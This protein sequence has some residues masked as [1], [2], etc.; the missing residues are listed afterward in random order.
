MVHFHGYDPVVEREFNKA[1]IDSALVIVNYNGFSSVYSGPF[2]NNTKLEDILN[3]AVR[4]TATARNVAN[5]TLGKVILCA[6]SAGYGAT[7]EILKSGRYDSLISDVVLIDGLH[8]GYVSNRQPN[9]TTMKPFLDYA[10]KASRGMDARMIISHSSIVPYTYASTT[11]TAD[12]L[13]AGV[14]A[15]SIPE[16][17]LNSAGMTKARRSDLGY[18]HVHG[19][20]GGVAQDHVDQLQNMGLWLKRVSL[21]K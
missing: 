11:E 8:S 1:N 16:S 12:Y 2:S 21:A 17:G 5:P 14:G 18:F 4:E 9:P 19:F 20:T 7:R 13:I 6:F 3:E 15:A 10:L